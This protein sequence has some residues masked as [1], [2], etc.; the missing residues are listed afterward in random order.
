MNA[1]S[2]DGRLGIRGVAGNSGNVR[3]ILQCRDELRQRGDRRNIDL[4]SRMKLPD[5]RPAYATKVLFSKISR[6]VSA[7]DDPDSRRTPPQN[8]FPIRRFSFP[9][10][11]EADKR[12]RSYFAGRT[13]SYKRTRR[14]DRRPSI[15]DLYPAGKGIPKKSCPAHA[16]PPKTPDAANSVPPD[17]GCGGRQRV[18]RK[19]TVGQPRTPASNDR[20][21]SSEG[22]PF[23]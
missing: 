16:R 14:H 2:A 4:R 6:F 9:S 1:D 11:S 7:F 20:S 23:A 8:I 22:S 12:S 3:D 17:R 15:H 5:V 10:A 18:D 21:G 19:R 13:A